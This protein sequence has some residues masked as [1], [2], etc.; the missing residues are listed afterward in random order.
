MDRLVL[1]ELPREE[2][3]VKGVPS[4]SIGAS[5]STVSSVARS[6]CCLSVKRGEE[7]LASQ[8]A[9]I[10][11]VMEHFDVPSKVI[12]RHRVIPGVSG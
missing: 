6:C 5:L 12:D 2:G 8:R 1:H 4:Q 11:T 7:R 10:V 9:D 3:K